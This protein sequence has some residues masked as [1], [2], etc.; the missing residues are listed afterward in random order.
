MRELQELNEALASV[1]TNSVLDFQTRVQ[2]AK[3]IMNRMGVR[4]YGSPEA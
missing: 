2:M 4:P 3:E 1:V